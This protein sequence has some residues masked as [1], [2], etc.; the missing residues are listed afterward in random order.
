GTVTNIG[1]VGLPDDYPAAPLDFEGDEYVGER[2]LVWNRNP[3][4]NPK[5]DNYAIE[6]APIAASFGTISDSNEVTTSGGTLTASS[7]TGEG[8]APRSYPIGVR[9]PDPLRDGMVRDGR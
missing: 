9:R 1:Y 5:D 4:N 8:G 2:V 6:N 3:V 7:V